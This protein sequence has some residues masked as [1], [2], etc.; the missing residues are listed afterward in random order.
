MSTDPANPENQNPQPEAPPASPPA[1]TA[2]PRAPLERSRFGGTS[3]RPARADEDDAPFSRSDLSKG[4]KELMEQ[5]AARINWSV[6]VISSV[7]ILAFSI[8]AM[9]MP[10]GARTTMK[11]AVDWIATNLG[12]YYVLTMALVIGTP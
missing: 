12:W 11:T 1:T 6:L 9:L 4:K 5:G 7:V 3:P 2:A 8:W 10:D